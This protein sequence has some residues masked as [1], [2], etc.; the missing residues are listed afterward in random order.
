VAQSAFLPLPFFHALAPTLQRAMDRCGGG[1]QPTLE[2]LQREADIA[3]AAVIAASVGL[4]HLL[5]DVGRHRLI[6][7]GFHGDSA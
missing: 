2:D 6:E 4:V 7:V 5:T 1:R 3:A